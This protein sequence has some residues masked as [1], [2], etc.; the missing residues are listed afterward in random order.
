V[1]GIV[2]SLKRL[3]GVPPRHIVQPDHMT[4]GPDVRVGARELAP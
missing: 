1:G 3:M 4:T 2:H